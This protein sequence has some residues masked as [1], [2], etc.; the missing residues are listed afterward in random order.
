[1]PRRKRPFVLAALGG[2]AAT[3][4]D[5]C[6]L[7]ALAER[8]VAIALAAFLGSVCG[9]GVAFGFNKYLA[10]RDRRP[11]DRHQLS[12]FALVSGTTALLMAGAMHIVC[13]LG[14]VPYLVGKAGCALVV[15]AV[16]T[17][18]AQRRLVFAAF[19]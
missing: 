8:G 12:S 11:I 4:L 1:M 2:L 5:V 6:V 10:F 15:F 7:A 9:A 16:W 19:H 3:A 14:H 13:D 18:P 17:Y